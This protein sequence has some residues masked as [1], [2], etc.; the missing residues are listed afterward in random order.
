MIP[1]EYSR[2]LMPIIISQNSSFVLIRIKWETAQLGAAKFTILNLEKVSS[3][4]IEEL[5]EG[6]SGHL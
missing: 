1:T 2:I 3:I 6:H 4:A 5:L